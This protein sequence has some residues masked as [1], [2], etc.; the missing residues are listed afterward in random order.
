MKVS[1][2]IKIGLGGVV[3]VRWRGELGPCRNGQL[4]DRRTAMGFGTRDQEPDLD[5]ADPNRLLGGI[6]PNLRIL[7][8][9]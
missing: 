4:E 3:A 1:V 8:D 9:H 2:T 5:H 6:Q 7:L